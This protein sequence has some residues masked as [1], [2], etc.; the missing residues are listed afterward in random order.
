MIYFEPTRHLANSGYTLADAVGFLPEFLDERWDKP[1]AAQLDMN[2]KH[3]G[4]WQP[5]KGF[6]M[7]PNTHAISYPGDPDMHP[8]AVASL[9]NEK[10]FV[11][12]SGWVA[13]VQPDESFE[14]C[15]MD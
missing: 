12:P 11:Y 8:L 15:R 14:I 6:Q 2:Y 7:D 1:A 4:G 5:F 10:I 9:H 3:G 13:V